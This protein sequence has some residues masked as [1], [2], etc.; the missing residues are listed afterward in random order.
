MR[1]LPALVVLACS[2]AGLAQPPEDALVVAAQ[3][4][5]ERLQSMVDA[6]ALPRATVERARESLADA[7]DAAILRRTAASD[8]NLDQAEEM[9]AAAHRRVARRE[10]V[11]DD[12]KHLVLAGAAAKASL[13]P[14]VDDLEQERQAAKLSES[15]AQAIRELSDMVSAEGN[16]INR[17]AHSPEEA[18]ALAEG[19]YADGTFLYATYA[20]VEM[21]YRERFGKSMPVSALGET[22]VHRAMGFDHRGRVDVALNPDQPEGVWLME[23]LKEN[24]IPFI[25]FRGPVKG[26]ATG[27]H[28]HIGPMSTRLPPGG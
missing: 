17:L 8:L 26:A 25:A 22:A 3:A 1:F 7:Q 11:L 12:A 20:K 21:A 5:L 9:V 15:R 18:A 19:Y 6:G 27:A 4:E 2:A 10:K 16:F 13:L 23:Y 28:I 24:G 14:L